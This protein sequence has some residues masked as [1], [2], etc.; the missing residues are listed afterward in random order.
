MNIDI[1]K[2]T[3]SCYELLK[4]NG[5]VSDKEKMHMS[6]TEREEE[7][8]K[9]ENLLNNVQQKLDQKRESESGEFNDDKNNVLLFMCAAAICYIRNTDLNRYLS[10]KIKNN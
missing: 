9:L 7:S 8:K 5:I 10:M 3:S 6:F 2:I 4:S 1:N